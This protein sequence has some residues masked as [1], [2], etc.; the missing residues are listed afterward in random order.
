[1]ETT[2]NVMGLY[3]VSKLF[4]GGFGGI[5]LHLRIVL[6]VQPEAARVLGVTFRLMQRGL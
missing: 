6:V 1:M 2:T 3:W 4:A 5:R